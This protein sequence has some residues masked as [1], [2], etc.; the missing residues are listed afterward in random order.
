MAY[1]KIKHRHMLK[2]DLTFV[3]P[4]EF[5]FTDAKDIKPVQLH[6]SAA[7]ANRNFWKSWTECDG[8]EFVVF[9]QGS[10]G[11]RVTQ[12]DGTVKYYIVDIN[13]GKVYNA[14]ETKSAFHKNDWKFRLDRFFGI[15]PEMREAG[16]NKIHVIHALMF[17]GGAAIVTGICGLVA[18]YISQAIGG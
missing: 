15:T 14:I 7:E 16:S 1:N 5:K 6:P 17:L 3:N 11:L 12:E 18:W 4:E 8:V 10:R 9:P 13:D 2:D